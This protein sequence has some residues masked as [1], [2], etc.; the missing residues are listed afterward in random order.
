MARIEDKN[1]AGHDPAFSD[2]DEIVA[3]NLAQ[4]VPGTEIC[5]GAKGLTFDRC[6]L[7][8]AVVPAD[9]K[10]IHC[11]VSQGALL[12][13]PDERLDRIEFLRAKI[14][15]LE[16]ELVALEQALGAPLGHGPGGEV[17]SG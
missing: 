8:R 1:F 14:A 15:E 16:A 4:A 5:Q 10:V 11:N 17:A 3:C 9:A 12:P 6:N 13:E 7:V 2:G